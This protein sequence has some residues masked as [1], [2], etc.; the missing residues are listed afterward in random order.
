[1]GCSA[2]DPEKDDEENAEHKIAKDL[3]KKGV[4]DQTE[5]E[6]EAAVAAAVVLAVVYLFIVCK[7]LTKNN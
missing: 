5:E 4:I 3:Q 2:D 7:G 1:M 6:L